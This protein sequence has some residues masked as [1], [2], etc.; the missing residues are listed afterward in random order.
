[1]GAVNGVGFDQFPK[2]SDWV[3]RKC[4]VCFNY[5]TSRTLT[6]TIVRDDVTEPWQTII[7]LD[8]GRLVLATECHYSPLAHGSSTTR[9]YQEDRD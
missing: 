1:M 9:R 3:G 8:D 6:G 4:D 2:Q 5:D 7:L